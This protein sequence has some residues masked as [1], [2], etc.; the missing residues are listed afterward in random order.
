MARRWRVLALSLPAFGHG[1]GADAPAPPRGVFARPGRLTPG[2]LAGWKAQGAS[3]L[4]VAVE[5][6]AS[7][8]P[9]APVGLPCPPANR[10]AGPTRVMS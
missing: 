1:A 5:S 3:A 10:P 6:T 9:A 2:F 7:D 8:R 4:V